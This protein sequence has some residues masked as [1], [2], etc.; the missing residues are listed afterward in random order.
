MN[1]NLWRGLLA[2]VFTTLACQPVIA[3]GGREVLVVFLLAMVLLGPP[4]YRLVRR[5]ETSFRQTDKDK[6][7]HAK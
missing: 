4:L 5:F 3:V 7:N 1:K 2:L 6:T